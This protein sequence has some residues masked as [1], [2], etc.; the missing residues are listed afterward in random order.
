M[1]KTKLARFL[2]L[3]AAA[4]TAAGACFYHL[5]DLQV[6]HGEE[7]K[8]KSERTVLRTSTIKA[9]RGEILDRYGRPLVV[10][11]ESFNLYIDKVSLGQSDLN[12]LIVRVS[13]LLDERGEKY[14]D[15]LPLNRT[16]VSYTVD[17]GGETGAAARVRQLAAELELEERPDAAA[18][19][20]ALRKKY[21]IDDGYTDVQARTIASIRWEMDNRDFS[22]TNPVNIASGVSIE[23]VTRIKEQN[24]Y[25]RGID[26][27][28]EPVREYVDGTIAPHILGRIGSI[29]KDEY[30]ALKEQGYAMNDLVGKDGAEKAFERYLRGTNGSRTVEQNAMGRIV[31]VAAEVDAVPGSNVL[32]T[33]DKDL[34]RVAQDSLERNIL[35]IAE[36]GEKSRSKK[37]ADANAG[38]VAVLDVSSAAVLAMASYPTYDLS[39]FNEDYGMLYNDPLSPMYNRALQGKYAPGSTFKMLTA[40]AGL[41]SG[42]ITPDTKIR[43]TGRY[44]R[45]A[46]TGYR[47]RCWIFTDYGSTHGLINVRQAIEKSCNIFFFETG[48]RMG[49]DVLNE[50]GRKFGLGEY[51]GIEL[52]G[53]SK[54]VLA[55]RQNS[56]EKGEI[57]QGGQTIQA[58]IGQSDNMFTPLQ[59]ANYVATLVNGGIRYNV[60]LLSSARDYHTGEVVFEAV[61]DAVLD[62]GLSEETME[63]VRDGMRKVTEDGTASSV[64]STYPIAVG[65]KTGSAE[66]PDGSAN[67]IFVCYAP[68]DDPK[69]AIAIVVEHGAHGNSVAPIARDIMDEYF[70]PDVEDAP[71]QRAWSLIQ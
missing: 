33:I 39:R 71:I 66:V 35:S 44:E 25:Y 32:L 3:L 34:Q 46:S 22:V 13:G 52:S 55:G 18:L 60:H 14:V 58:A 26:V 12:E 40:T 21:K 19:L 27:V 6:A 64:F 16:G 15:P 56:F 67:G 8:Q 17:I 9:I 31:G 53:E 65:G 48:Y 1:E 23:T 5:A 20:S 43:C 28:Q 42:A 54:G 57:W 63:V 29:Y 70:A 47:P 62:L 24:E 41:E 51:T 49:I 45:F 4:L 68:I 30:P 37:G 11:S 10:N 2:A 36:K 50:Y 61:P 38:A 7:Y 59:L 69:I